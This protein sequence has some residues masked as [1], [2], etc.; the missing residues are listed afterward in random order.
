MT[1]QV[2]DILPDLTLLRPN[3]DEVRLSDFPRPTLLI[4]L[5]HLH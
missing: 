4:F 5:R 2:G 1:V 3:G